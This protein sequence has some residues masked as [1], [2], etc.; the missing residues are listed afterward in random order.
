MMVFPL[1]SLY[2]KVNLHAGSHKSTYFKDYCEHTATYIN[3]LAFFS[4]HFYIFECE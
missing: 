2:C 1:R 4:G 3:V